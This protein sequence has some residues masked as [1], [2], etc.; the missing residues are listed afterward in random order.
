MLYSADV[1]ANH[2]YDHEYDTNADF[3]IAM[4]RTYHANHDNIGPSCN[5]ECDVHDYRD[6]GYDNIKHDDNMDANSD[7]RG[8]MEC[9]SS[10]SLC[11]HRRFSG[12]RER[13]CPVSRRIHEDDHWKSGVYS[14]P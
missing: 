9:D 14:V 5:L 3:G 1:N 10:Y 6:N 8:G 12:R 11:V 7:S 2:E 13:L 4:A